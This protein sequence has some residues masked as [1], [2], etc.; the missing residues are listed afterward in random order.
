MSIGRRRLLTSQRVA[1]STSV[2][3]SIRSSVCTC[4]V[5]LVVQ[6]PDRAVELVGAED[7]PGGDLGPDHVGR[8]GPGLAGQPVEAGDARLR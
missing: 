8:A 1:R 7:R 3:T 4:G 5:D 6:R 2:R